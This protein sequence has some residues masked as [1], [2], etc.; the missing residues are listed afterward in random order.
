M[1]KHRPR[2]RQRRESCGG[3]TTLARYGPEHFA[4]IGRLGAL[5]SAAVRRVAP[6]SKRMTF[7]SIGFAPDQLAELNLMAVEQQTSTAAL[8]R[9]ACRCLL[10]AWK[11]V[12]AQRG[13]AGR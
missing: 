9:E 4:K 13:L 3:K 1:P 7:R 11:E 10:I 2:F 12:K 5:R 6:A 8:I